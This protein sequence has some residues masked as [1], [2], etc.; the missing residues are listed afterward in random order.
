MINKAKVENLADGLRVLIETQ[1]STSTLVPGA[2]IRE[3]GGVTKEMIATTLLCL[4]DEVGELAKELGYKPW[5]PVDIDNDKVK[6]EFAD[7][8]AF[9]GLT[10]YYIS[11][12]TGLTPE[13][14]AEAYRRKTQENIRRFIGASENRSYLGVSNDSNYAAW[15]L[16]ATERDDSE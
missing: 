13:D 4:V 16:A 11:A 2:S 3:V 10:T 14:L 6:D 1:K 9:L 8:L 5:K 7:I 12:L 15:L